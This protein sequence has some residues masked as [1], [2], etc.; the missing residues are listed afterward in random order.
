[1][2]GNWGPFQPVIHILAPTGDGWSSALTIRFERRINH[3]TTPA[4]ASFDWRAHA[5][6]STRQ[7]E[8]GVIVAGGHPLGIEFQVPE[9][10]TQELDPGRYTMTAVLD[11][12]QVP[13]EEIWRGRIEA[14]PVEFQL[15]SPGNP[16][17][18]GSV[19]A[20]R[21]YRILG[22]DGKSSEGLDMARRAVALEPDSPLAWALLGEAFQSAGPQE[23][24]LAVL[25]RGLRWAESQPYHEADHS[26]M[27]LRNKTQQLR[28]KLARE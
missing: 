9:E 20:M 19:L 16:H 18:E 6:T 4:L 10:V 25:E 5:R 7:P 24:G 22:R 12:T 26:Y 17:A 11:T 1:V 28:E 14:G 21:A 2:D 13:A 15:Q 27:A 8:L 23:E 3:G